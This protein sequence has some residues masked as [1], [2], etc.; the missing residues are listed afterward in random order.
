MSYERLYFYDKERRRGVY[1][2]DEEIGQEGE[3]TSG[4]EQ[5][6]AE[7]AAH[8]PYGQA[9]RL[10][11]RLTGV[12]LSTSAVWEIVQQA[13]QM[14]RPALDPITTGKPTRED[15]RCLA[16]TMDGCMSNIREEGWKEVK[17]GAVFEANRVSEHE[18]EGIKGSA[19]SYVAHL[20]GPEGFATKLAAEA[21]SRGFHQMEQQ[22]VVGD[23]AAWIWNI[24]HADYPN[25]AHIVDW[26]HAREHLYAAANEIFAGCP[27]SDKA[28]WIQTHTDLLFN[29]DAEKI[30]CHLEAHAASCQLPDISVSRL[31][32]EAGYFRTHTQRM[33]YADFRNASLPIGSGVIES[34]AKRLKQRV[35]G[36]GMRWSRQGLENLLPLRTAVMS[37]TFHLLWHRI[38]P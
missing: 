22:A 10:Y 37:D 27:E 35:S 19:Q 28:A 25:A 14:A 36:P 17:I 6:L 1:P 13:G 34:G 3:T 11:S 24:A 29:G 21:H 30:A 12:K 20:G 5:A 8:M 18:D 26:F 4:V 15:A 38:C 2:F 7:L 32:T 33:Q 16:V 9:A 23:G 31:N